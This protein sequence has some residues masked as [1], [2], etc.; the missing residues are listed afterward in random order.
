MQPLRKRH[1]STE[2]TVA[3]R[4]RSIALLSQHVYKSAEENIKKAQAHQKKHYDLRHAVPAFKKGDLV[5]R[6]NMANSHRMGG[7]LDARWIGPYTIHEVNEKELYRLKCTKS[8]KVLK[9]AISSL[10]LKAY[11]TRPLADVSYCRTCSLYSPKPFEDFSLFNIL[12]Q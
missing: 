11:S 8:G 12:T 1:L 4:L 3:K 10:Q 9:K 7:K 2:D 5:L 6:K